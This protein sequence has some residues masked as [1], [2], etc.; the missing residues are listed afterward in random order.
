M[1][2]PRWSPSRPPNGSNCTKCGQGGLSYPQVGSSLAPSWP[3]RAQVSSKMAKAVAK[4]ALRWPK[5]APRWPQDGPSRHQVGFKM[6]EVGPKTAQTG[7]SLAPRGPKM[8]SSCSQV[9]LTWLQ[10]CMKAD[11]PKMLEKTMKNQRI[12]TFSIPKLGPI[13]PRLTPNRH[14]GGDKSAQVGSSWLK[15]GSSWPKLAPS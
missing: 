6:S 13:L 14:Q 2:D 1:W 8:T 12:S 5:L 10:Y 4:M 7:P 3:E 15:L 11:K 9:G